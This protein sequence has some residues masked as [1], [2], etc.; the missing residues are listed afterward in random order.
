MALSPARCLCCGAEFFARTGRNLGRPHAYC[1]PCR[2]HAQATRDGRRPAA[3][4][5]Q[6]M[7]A[8]V[9]VEMEAACDPVLTARPPWGHPCAV[10]GGL[11]REGHPLHRRTLDLDRAPGLVSAQGGSR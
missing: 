5:Q 10:C 7:T 9:P 4:G 2:P 8:R 11:V 3:C 1:S 6:W